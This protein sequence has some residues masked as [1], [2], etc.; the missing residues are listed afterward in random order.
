[1]LFSILEANLENSG[2]EPMMDAINALGGWP[3]LGDRNTAGRKRWTEVN[4][5]YESNYWIELLA[6]VRKLGFDHDLFFKLEVRSDA[7]NNS[8]IPHSLCVSYD[9]RQIL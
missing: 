5:N 4:N 8:Y 7:A 3:V 9:G 1:M 2:D 6:L